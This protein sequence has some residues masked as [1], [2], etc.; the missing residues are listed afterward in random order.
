MLPL[1]VLAFGAF[2][3]LAAALLAGA[4]ASI[5]L[6]LVLGL[7]GLFVVGGALVER[8]QYRPRIRASRGRWEATG[9]RFIDP[10]TRQEIE[11]FYNPDTGQRDYR[12]TGK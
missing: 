7:S 4:G 5:I 3:I 12:E 1:F 10:G 8:S 6:I 11:V 2:E 9:E